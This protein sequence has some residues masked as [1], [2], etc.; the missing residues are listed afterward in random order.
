MTDPAE[1]AIEEIIKRLPV[2][3]VYDDGLSGAT[4][5]VGHSL[6]DVA[7]SIRLALFP[8][9]FLAAMQDRVEKFIDRAIEG[10][11]KNREFLPCRRSLDRFSRAF[12]MNPKER[13]ST[14]CSRNC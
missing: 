2:K 11:Q 3:Q 13:Q 6:T 14:K 7:K 1:K 5:Q 4:K 10:F 8:F 12:V 9:Q